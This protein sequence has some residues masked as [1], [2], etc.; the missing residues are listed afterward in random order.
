MSISALIILAIAIAIAAGYKTNINIGF[1]ALSFTYLIGSFMM[2]LSIAELFSLWPMKLF[3]IILGVSLF[4][5]FSIT[6]GTL[7]KLAMYILYACRNMVSA[8]PFIIFFISMLIAGM[9]AGYFATVA[10]LCP[11]SM[12]LCEKTGLNRMLGIFA[13][14]FGA[15]AGANFMSSM[16]GLIF[17]GLIEHA[18]YAEESFKYATSIFVMTTIEPLIIML[19]IQLFSKQTAL[20][21]QEL[22]IEKPEPFEKKQIITLYLIVALILIVL[23]PPLLHMF[24]PDNA[25][26]TFINKKTDVGFVAIILSIVALLCKLGD[27]KTII[28]NVPWGTIIML[29]SVGMLI[30]IAVKA[31]TIKILAGWLTGSISAF[32]IPVVITALAGFMSFFSSTAG[33][34]APALFPVVKILEEHTGVSA[35]LMFT[36]II[37]GSQCTGAVSPFS[38]GGSLAL[39]SCKNDEE[40]AVL[41]KK[42]MFFATPATYIAVI[43]IC[44]IYG[45]IFNMF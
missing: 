23:T 1:Y 21:S 26:I 10:F 37:M 34:V 11:I 2:N 5:N 22:Q 16:F 27:E 4:Y 30:G 25:T 44:F 8:L 31:G 24:F 3:F 28:S 17:A 29:C 43:V 33:V 20:N 18:G 42:L 14:T 38:S 19:G 36:C 12:I 7:G 13:V 35:M 9:G 40:R 41:F 6:N 39:A 45:I 32:F 15:C